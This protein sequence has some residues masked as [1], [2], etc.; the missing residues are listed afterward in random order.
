[1]GR[2]PVKERGYKVLVIST[3]RRATS[4]PAG[5]NFASGLVAIDDRVG[6]IVAIR[7]L[8]PQVRRSSSLIPE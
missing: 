8:P 5:I 1:M 7:V 2:V 6:S 4:S 3:T